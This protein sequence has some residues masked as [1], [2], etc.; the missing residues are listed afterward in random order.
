MLLGIIVLF[1]G[2][3][4]LICSDVHDLTKKKK[5]AERS[6]A[7]FEKKLKEIQHKKE[8]LDEGNRRTH[9]IF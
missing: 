9:Y 1:I 7:I 4:F 2:I 3:F 8:I 5:K 6:K